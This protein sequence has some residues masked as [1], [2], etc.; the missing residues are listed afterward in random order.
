MVKEEDCED[1]ESLSGD[2]LREGV[3]FLY[4]EIRKSHNKKKITYI[5]NIVINVILDNINPYLY[6]ILTMLIIMILMNSFQFYYYITNFSI[7][8]LKRSN[9]NPSISVSGTT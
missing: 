8:T 6:T 3:N 7:D 1:R 2:L 4:N 5:L 9:L